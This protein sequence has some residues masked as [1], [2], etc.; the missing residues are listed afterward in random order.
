MNLVRILEHDEPSV[1]IKAD[2]QFLA[3]RPSVG[4]QSSAKLWIEPR[5][6]HDLRTQCRRA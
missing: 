1:V 5:F 4:K 2:P 6:D 3:G